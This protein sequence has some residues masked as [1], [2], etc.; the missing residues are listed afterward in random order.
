MTKA[1]KIELGNINNRIS[2]DAIKKYKLDELP[3][4]YFITSFERIGMFDPF[5]GDKDTNTRTRDLAKNQEIKQEPIYEYIYP[6][7]KMRDPET[8]PS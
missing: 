4:D 8:A 2:S 6:E 1:K 7:Y 5:F 3:Q